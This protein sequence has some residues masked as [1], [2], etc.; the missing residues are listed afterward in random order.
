MAKENLLELLS[1]NG[2]YYLELEAS[3]KSSKQM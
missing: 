2:Y 1:F 3:D